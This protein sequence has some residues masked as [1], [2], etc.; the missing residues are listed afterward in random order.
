MSIPASLV[1]G[2]DVTNENV[3]TKKLFPNK[4]VINLNV[5]SLS[6]KNWIMSQRYSINIY[7]I[8][9]LKLVDCKYNPLTIINKVLLL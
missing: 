6:M 4:V 9:V 3:F 8:Y 7:W 1:V 2:R 5:F